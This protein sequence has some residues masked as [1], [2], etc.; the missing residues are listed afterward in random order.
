MQEIAVWINVVCYITLLV[1]FQVK[2]KSFRLG[3]LALSIYAFSALA[4]MF[5]FNSILSSFVNLQIIPFLFLFT[6]FCIVV[7]PILKFDSGQVK[8]IVYNKDMVYWL[9]LFIGIISIIPAVEITYLLTKVSNMDESIFAELHQMKNTGEGTIDALRLS[10]ISRPFYFF[11]SKISDIS[12]ILLF[13]QIASPKRNWRIIVLLLISIYCGNGMGVV[14]GGRSA[15]T[16]T[17]IYLFALYLIFEDFLPT[18]TK[19]GVKLY[20]LLGLSGIVVVFLIITLA[21]FNQKAV[22]SEVGVIDWISLYAG[23]GSLDFNEYVWNMRGTTQGD[24]CF[25]YFKDLLDF[26]S[27]KKGLERR[28]YFEVRTNI[29]QQIFYTFIGNIIEDFGKAWGALFLVVV[30]ILIRKGTKAKNSTLN[31]SNLIVLC[32]W[33]KIVFSGITFYTYAGSRAEILL[34]NLILA[35][36]CL[37]LRNDTA[38]DNKTITQSNRNRNST[39][40]QKHK[41]DLHNAVL[42]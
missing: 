9:S 39:L 32:L 38:I 16:Y 17:A 41:D 42:G 25:S 28:D 7:R 1:W 36:I 13:I 12:P 3:S 24:Y 34:T 5:F 14:M 18:Q 33:C 22:A 11:V 23:E 26:D 27:V 30:S 40:L 21:R 15:L 19:K 2:V 31:L 4:G 6:L 29:P 8:K 20:G 37:L 10:A 35:F